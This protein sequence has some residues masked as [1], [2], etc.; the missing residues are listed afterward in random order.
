VL[1]L[2]ADAD[3]YKL[4]AQHD[5]PIQE[6]DLPALVDA[7]RHRHELLPRWEARDPNGEWREKWWFADVAAIRA[8]DFYLSAGRYR[9]L[10]QTQAEHQEPRELLDELK[11]IEVEIMQELEALSDKLRETAA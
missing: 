5:T 11:A 6:D 4:D 8:N 2:H 9:P 1:F 3:G 10:T 7:F